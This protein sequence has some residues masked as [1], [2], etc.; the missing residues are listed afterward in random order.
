[1]KI[2]A[3]VLAAGSGKRMGMGVKKQYMKLGNNPVLFYS[4]DAFE[5]SNID[6]VYLVTSRE[7]IDQVKAEYMNERFSKVKGVIPGGKERYNSV[8]NGL[9]AI[10]DCDYVFIHDGARPFI[11]NDMIDRLILGVKEYKACVAGMPAKDTVKITD[12]DGYVCD[13]PNRNNVWIVQT[14]Q[15]FEFSIIYNAYS[16]LIELENNNGLCDLNITDDAMVVEYFENVK[17]KMIEGSYNNIKITTIEDI[18]IA[19]AI[20][21]SKNP[22]TK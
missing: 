22:C 18:P 11:D 1:M 2:V 8:F 3:I 20:L 17:V 6:E 13:T 12:K 14:P 16:K 7:D 19:E 5:K 15:C 10:E 4:L 9:K 21:S